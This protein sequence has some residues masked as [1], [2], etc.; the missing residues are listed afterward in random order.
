VIQEGYFERGEWKE[1]K[2]EINSYNPNI[3][4]IAKKV[5]FSKYIKNLT[6]QDLV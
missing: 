5:E 3:H 4:L 2:D 1:K 6:R